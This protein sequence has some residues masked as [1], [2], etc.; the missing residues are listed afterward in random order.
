MTEY[1]KERG[2]FTES[3]RPRTSSCQDEQGYFFDKSLCGGLLGFFREEGGSVVDLGCGS[4][5]Y[6]KYLRDNEIACDCYDGNPHTEDMTNGLCKCL[7]ISKKIN[8]KTYDW[9]MALEVGEHIPKEYEDD[10]IYNLHTHN[11][12]GIVVTWAVKGQGGIGHVNCQ[13]NDYIKKI[14]A[15]LGYSNDIKTETEL[16][17]V[18]QV[19][20]FKNTIMIFK[21]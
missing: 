18:S 10:F 19:Q 17:A 4:G 9:V 13:N 20:W 12:K 2:Y 3:S 21:K 7:D 11:K 6:T 5:S 16:R 8:I 14:F 15:N 1:N